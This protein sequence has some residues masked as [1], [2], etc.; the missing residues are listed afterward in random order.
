MVVCAL[1]QDTRSPVVRGSG[2]GGMGGPAEQ[3][4]MWYPSVKH[5]GGVE[6]SPS[7]SSDD[8]GT[9]NAAS[10]LAFLHSSG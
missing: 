1:S 3:P 6:P 8:D 4:T 5:A 10:L 7:P 2:H 9:T